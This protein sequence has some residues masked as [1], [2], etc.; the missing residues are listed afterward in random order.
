MLRVKLGGSAVT[1]G[2]ALPIS[3]VGQRNIR[4]TAGLWTLLGDSYW[5]EGEAESLL[6]PR[7]ASVQDSTF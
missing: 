7:G 5:L 2:I 1:G 6:Q 3:V 4:N